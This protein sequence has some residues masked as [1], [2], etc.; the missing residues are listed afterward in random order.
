MLEVVVKPQEALGK[1]LLLS[2][3][4]GAIKVD[5]RDILVSLAVPWLRQPSKSHPG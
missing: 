3:S 2:R 1:K 5:C 4:V